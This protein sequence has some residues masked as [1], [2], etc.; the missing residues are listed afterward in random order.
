MSGAGW[1][2]N[3]AGWKIW[4]RSVRCWRICVS[5]PR[6][7]TIYRQA[8][9]S[10]SDVSPFAVAWVCFQLGVLWGELASEPELAVAEQWY[11][12]A[13]D[14]SALL[15]EGPGASG[16]DLFCDGRSGDAEAR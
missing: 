3:P 6:P 7:T 1:R 10:Y 16:G 12:K 4:W 13:I 14:L 8:L 15:C 2:R 11:R 9:R 5:F